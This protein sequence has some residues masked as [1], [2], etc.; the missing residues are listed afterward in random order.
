MDSVRWLRGATPGAYSTSRNT[1]PFG[2][3][4]AS[5]RV[6]PSAAPSLSVGNSPVDHTTQLE[7][8]GRR[9]ITFLQISSM[10]TIA[11]PFCS[12]PVA[13]RRICKAIVAPLDASDAADLGNR[14]SDLSNQAFSDRLA[15]RATR[16]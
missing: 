11:R 8:A 12:W 9:E 2:S 5:G 4:V 7:C 16:R 3:T 13:T 14:A 6:P 15:A 10:L 1:V